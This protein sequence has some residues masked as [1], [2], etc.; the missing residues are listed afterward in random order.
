[1]ADTVGRA[2]A[3]LPHPSRRQ[4]WTAVAGTGAGS[5]R[6]TMGLSHVQQT[7]SY[8]KA[9]ST[10]AAEGCVRVPADG[11]TSSLECVSIWLS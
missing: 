6:V 8:V 3:L 5:M 11:G 10:E 7:W 1:M 2:A 9:C 4:G